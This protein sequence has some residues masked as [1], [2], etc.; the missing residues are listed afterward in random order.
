MMPEL[1]ASEDDLQKCPAINVDPADLDISAQGISNFYWPY[2]HKEIV[3]F[4]SSLEYGLADI[5]SNYPD[6]TMALAYK[7]AAKNFVLS[8]AT[9]F[10]G[11]ILLHRLNARHETLNLPEDWKI[12]RAFLKNEAPPDPFYLDQIKNHKTASVSAP[13]KRFKS[14]KSVS[15]LLMRASLGRLGVRLDGLYLPKYSLLPPANAIFA[16][17]RLSLIREHA[18]L[19][20]EPVYLCHSMQFF[21]P[22]SEADINS[23]L[24][25]DTLH[26]DIMDIVCKLFVSHGANIRPY[27]IS[28]LGD[29]LNKYVHAIR[30]HMDRLRHMPELPRRLWTGTAGNLWDVMLRCAVLQCGGEVVSHD[31][32]GGVPQLNHPEKGWIEMWSCNRFIC[33]GEEQAKTFRMFIG[34]WPCLDKNP[35]AIESLKKSSPRGEIAELKRYKED[36]FSIKS[37]RIF[38]TVYSSEDG[39]GLPLYPHVSYIDWQSR[40]IGYLKGADYDVTFRPHPDSRLPPPDYETKLDAAIINVPFD[41]MDNDFDLYIFDLSNTS[42]LQT[43]LLTNKPILII[44]F[45]IYE[46]R[47]DAKKLLQKRCGFVEGYYEGS[48]MMIDWQELDR[49]IRHSARLCNNHDF[50]RKFYL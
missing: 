30:I 37:V 47:D 7:I 6:Q 35:P 28:Y 27:I 13:L 45:G 10:M 12:W 2:S 50:A 22:I 33:Y 24:S 5:L 20:S 38:S 11:E 23:D 46:W 41:Q 19:V 36:D 32:G 18:L 1:L 3:S 16:T 49:Q 25:S 43:A 17:Q 31:H 42:V 26:K 9:C 15:A 44:D 29:S 40:L 8:V 21:Y 39:R 4:G 14:V 48:R 34:E